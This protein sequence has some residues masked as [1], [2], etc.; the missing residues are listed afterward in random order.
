LPLVACTELGV[1]DIQTG[2]HPKLKVVAALSAS[3]AQL[4]ELKST[5]AYVRSSVPVNASAPLVAVALA[6]FANASLLHHLNALAPTSVSSIAPLI[7]TAV[8]SD[9]PSNADAPMLVNA[10][11]EMNVTPTTLVH[12]LNAPAAIAVTVAS[13]AMYKLAPQHCVL[14]VEY[15]H[16]V[17]LV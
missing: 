2:G 11:A 1:A 5:V 9:I 16:V 17:V 8:S 3:A 10:V 12:I 7:S 13:I 14:P 15:V 4:A 6:S